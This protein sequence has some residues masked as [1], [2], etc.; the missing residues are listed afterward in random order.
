MF[1]SIQYSIKKCSLIFDYKNNIYFEKDKHVMC[2]SAVEL[3]C[4]K[5]KTLNSVNHGKKNVIS[6]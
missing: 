1:P 5:E 6:D 3:R 2:D 4:F